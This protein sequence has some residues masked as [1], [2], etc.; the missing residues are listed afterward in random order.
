VPGR[1]DVVAREG[2]HGDA[3][4]AV[5]LDPLAGLALTRDESQR[6][7]AVRS[8]GGH[9]DLVATGTR[10]PS[11]IDGTVELQERE[12]PSRSAE[13]PHAGDRLLARIAALRKMHVGRKEPEL[14]GQVWGTHLATPRRA[15]DADPPRL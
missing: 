13:H 8:D 4:A 9:A 10:G 12:T 7:V 11:G 6:Q 5:R 14:L 15:A 1:A 3:R 2:E